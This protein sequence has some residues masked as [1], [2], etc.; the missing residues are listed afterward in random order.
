MTWEELV[1]ARHSAMERIGKRDG[2]ERGDEL[3]RQA[4]GL[5]HRSAWEHV[6][7][8]RRIETDLLSA[9]RF[10]RVKSDQL[11]NVS[12]DLIRTFMVRGLMQASV[13]TGG[14]ATYWVAG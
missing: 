12:L 5:A 11:A 1:L 8:L 10:E 4:F 14:K 3:R 2:N 7:E 13:E 9:S 6:Y